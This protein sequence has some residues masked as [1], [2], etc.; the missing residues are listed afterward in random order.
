MSQ[1][2]ARSSDAYTGSGEPARRADG[3]FRCA[4]TACSALVHG[5]VAVMTSPATPPSA[6]LTARA[7]ARPAPRPEI[8]QV[9]TEAH[10][11]R[12]VPPLLEDVWAVAP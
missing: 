11:A 10:V 5:T 7:H 4:C 1:L 2:S 9:S 6:T 8:V 3:A 12:T